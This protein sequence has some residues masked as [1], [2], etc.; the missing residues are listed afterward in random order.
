[1]GERHAAP[2]P[3]HLHA[4]CGAHS[5]PGGSKR[6][7][8]RLDRLGH[9]GVHRFLVLL[10][11]AGHQDLQS[12]Q[13]VQLR[14][15]GPGVLAAHQAPAAAPGGGARPSRRRA[16]GAGGVRPLLRLS[17]RPPAVL[18]CVLLRQARGDHRRHRPGGLRQILSGQGLSVRDALR[19]QHPLRRAGALRPDPGGAGHRGGL[20]G[21]PAGAA[22]RL[23]GRQHPAGRRRRPRSLAS[24]RVSGPG[25]RRHARRHG[26]SGGR[27]GRPALR[28]AAGPAGPGPDPVP[29]AA[30]ADPGRSLLRRGQGD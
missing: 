3:H 9:R 18:R 23:H 2:V 30:P 13:A 26:H 19:R 10:Y 4:G 28:R 12:R 6:G 22:Q 1:M 29:Q 21:P 16:G 27:C 5:V 17:R 15:E 24:R 25:D 11:Q 20:S 7:G 8:H 14:T